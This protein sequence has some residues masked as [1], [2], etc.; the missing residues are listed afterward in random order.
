M[1]LKPA[2]KGGQEGEYP[3]AAYGWG[4]GTF[5]SSS[6]CGP[7]L[8]M[9]YWAYGKALVIAV[10]Q[11]RVLLVLKWEN[12]C[13]V[14]VTPTASHICVI[15]RTAKRLI[16]G[17]DVTYVRHCQIYLCPYGFCWVFLQDGKCEP[18]NWLMSWN[19]AQKGRTCG[20]QGS[21]LLFFLRQVCPW[22]GN[23]YVFY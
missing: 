9:G 14:R 7:L 4:P 20:L 23:R 15:L 6:W 3:M 10:L 8:E 1:L 12:K 21:F 5:P 11:N 22:L 18:G 16:A 19:K 13:P 2:S 17:T